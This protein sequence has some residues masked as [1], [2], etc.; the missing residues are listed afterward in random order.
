[1]TREIIK[2]ANKSENSE[3]LTL[4]LTNVRSREN[5]LIFFLELFALSQSKRLNSEQY[6]IYK[7]EFLQKQKITT[8]QIKS[9]I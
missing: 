4:L 6:A 9:I 7:Q 3:D 2:F 8:E 1:M 5:T